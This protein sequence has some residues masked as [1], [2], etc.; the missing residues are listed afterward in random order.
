MDYILKIKSSEITSQ[1]VAPLKG[2]RKWICEILD[3]EPNR[4]YYFRAKVELNTIGNIFKGSLF[5]GEDGV[6]WHVTEIRGFNIKLITVNPEGSAV[7]GKLMYYINKVN[8]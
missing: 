8:N 5:R 4:R 2:L 7:I 1:E 3:I 6:M